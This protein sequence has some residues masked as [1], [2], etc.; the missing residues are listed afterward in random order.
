MPKNGNFRLRK[1]LRVE[2]FAERGFEIRFACSDRPESDFLAAL[3]IE[4]LGPRQMA[5]VSEGPG[6]L[7]VSRFAGSL[8]EDDLAA[9]RIWGRSQAGMVSFEAGPFVDAWH[10]PR[11]LQCF[12][13]PWSRRQTLLLLS[14]VQG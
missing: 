2:E 12:A 11:H 9:V 5:F 1:K 13:T 6:R 3:T 8:N 4:V 10:P 7:F 14:P